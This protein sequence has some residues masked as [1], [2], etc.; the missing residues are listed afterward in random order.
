MKESALKA[1]ITLADL[2]RI[3]SFQS[4]VSKDKRRPI[5]SGVYTSWGKSQIEIAATDSYVLATT[6]LSI[7]EC[8]LKFGDI[9]RILIPRD[10]TVAVRTF[11][12]IQRGINLK[13]NQISIN[14][15]SEHSNS[16]SIL[17]EMF[18]YA[19]YLVHTVYNDGIGFPDFNKLFHR[20]PEEPI[21]GPVTL[22]PVMVTRVAK[23]VKGP[24]IVETFGADNPVSLTAIDDESWRAL[25]MPVRQT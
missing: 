11:K 1:E 19:S 24:L 8:K 2:E 6:K 17:L 3:S 22:N 14:V 25:I 4:I 9:K 5:L 16:D 23:T 15:S 20:M 7:Y 18:G 12:V 13:P 10:L 21:A